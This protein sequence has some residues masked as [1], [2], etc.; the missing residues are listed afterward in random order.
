[1]KQLS[2]SGRWA[3]ILAILASIVSGGGVCKAT[4]GDTFCK[5]IEG[6]S[7]AYGDAAGDEA[8][9]EIV[10]QL[11][12]SGSVGD[13]RRAAGEGDVTGD[14]ATRVIVKQLRL[15]RSEEA[16]RRAAA[17]GEETGDAGWRVLA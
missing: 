1:M 15:G 10:K 14:D 9:R 3:F 8:T 17:A 16:L 11:R 12:P 2:G 5:A 4:N 6:D 13:V 7:G